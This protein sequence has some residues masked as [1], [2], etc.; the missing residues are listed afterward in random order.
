MRIIRTWKRYSPILSKS[1]TLNPLSD[2]RS[3]ED[4]KAAK[5]EEQEKETTFLFLAT[6]EKAEAQTHLAQSFA[7]RLMA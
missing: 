6:T 3:G 7:R 5:Q 2:D 1:V 4:E